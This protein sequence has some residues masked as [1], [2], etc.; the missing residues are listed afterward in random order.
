MRLRYVCMLAVLVGTSSLL[1]RGLAIEEDATAAVSDTDEVKIGRILAQK[2]EVENGISPTEQSRKIDAYLQK[3]GERLA[4]HAER[5]AEKLEVDPFLDGYG[6]DREFAADREGVKLAV[7][8]GYSAV[9]GVRLLRTFVILG[10]QMPNS[11]K[12]A[13]TNLEARIAQIQPIADASASEK[14]KETPLGLPQ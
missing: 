9:A 6:H 8:A 12:E 11:P 2:Y 1:T 13:K 10:E 3:V 14:R 5:N 7:A 4:A